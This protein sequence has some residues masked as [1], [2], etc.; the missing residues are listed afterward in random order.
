MCPRLGGQ[1]SFERSPCGEVEVHPRLQLA[2][3]V[4]LGGQDQGQGR[5]PKLLRV[6]RTRRRCAVVCDGYL[7]QPK[8][9]YAVE[10]AVQGFLVVDLAADERAAVIGGDD[11]HAVE[12]G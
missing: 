1:W 11:L 9:A 2:E 12:P 5:Q 7:W 8:V 4:L 6:S 3:P 10:E